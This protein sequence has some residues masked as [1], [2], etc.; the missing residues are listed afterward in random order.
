MTL[1]RLRFGS[2]Y[3]V[4]MRSTTRPERLRLYVIWW[5][6]NHGLTPSRH[7]L[8]EFAVLTEPSAASPNLILIV[9]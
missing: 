1:L 4:G 9:D 5:T 7:F 8:C 3:H 6:Y 2:S